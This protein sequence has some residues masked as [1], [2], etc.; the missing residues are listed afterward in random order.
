MKGRSPSIQIPE[1]TFR[2]L[3]IGLGLP[4]RTF[5]DLH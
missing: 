3:L 1:S 5:K 2:F 4:N